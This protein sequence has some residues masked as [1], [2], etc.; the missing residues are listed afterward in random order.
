MPIKWASRAVIR[1][2]K[3]DPA[4][5]AVLERWANSDVSKLKTMITKAREAQNRSE[6]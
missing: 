2:P 5:A 1:L 4:A 3:T 6:R